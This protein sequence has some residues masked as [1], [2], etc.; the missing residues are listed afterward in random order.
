MKITGRNK[1]AG[2]VVNI[3][4]GMVTC[5]VEI[6]TKGGDRVVGVI[7]K[8]SKEDLDIKIGDEITA[9]VKATSVMFIKE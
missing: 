5:E 9:L 2:K 1:L 7:T 4:E 8:S 3:V 6:E